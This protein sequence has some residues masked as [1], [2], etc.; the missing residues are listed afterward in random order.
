MRTSVASLAS[1]LSLGLASP[2]LALTI[3]NFEAGNYS[4]SSPGINQKQQAGLAG[5]DVVGG[6]RIVRVDRTNG[7]TTTSSLATTAGPDASVTAFTDLAPPLGQGQVT[8]TY[9]G[10]ADGV[11][12]GSGGALNLDM[13]VFTTIDVEASLTALDGI[14]IQVTMW[15]ATTSQSSPIATA[16][17]GN[18]AF[19]L[20]SF[21]LLDL[22]S[23]KTIRVALSGLDNGEAISVANIATDAVP[24]PE[25][26]TAALLAF[27]LASFAVRRARRQ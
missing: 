1:L 10:L 19:L 12:N 22:T 4:V 26:G 11:P 27:G 25:P 13:S 15:D 20:G 18:N 3:D 14:G 7:G 16:V 9:D 23:I 24:V 2:A 8:Y 21:G 6:V 5:S 17:N